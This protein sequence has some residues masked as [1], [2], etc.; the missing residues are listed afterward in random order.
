MNNN[1]CINMADKDV[2]MHYLTT[3]SDTAREPFVILD[4]ELIIVGANESFYKNFAVTKVE[5]VGKAIFDLGNGQWDIPELR[6]LLEKILPEKTVFN[7]YE[8]SHEFPHIG[9]KT[10]L[11]NAR[12]LD[13][14]KQ[15]L[16][17][18]ED[19]T[20]RREIEVRL[21]NYT[22][23]LE[24]GVATMTHD[25][26]ARIDELTR[27]NNLMVGRELKMIELKKQ[28]VDLKK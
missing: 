18:I 9:L 25:L 11:L 3:F 22:K 28:I 8:I 10:M 12:Q 20:L 27:L 14:T 7:D 2:A 6:E 13:S 4:H 1:E 23:D 24:K 15:I 26:N 16:L 19:I 17:A 5:T 21:S